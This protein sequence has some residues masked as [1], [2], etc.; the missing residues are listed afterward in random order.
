MGNLKQLSDATF[1]QDVLE[2]DGLVLVDFWAPWCGPC[3]AVAPV[4]EQIAREYEGRVTVA[5]LNVDENPETPSRYGVR[6]IPTIALFRGGEVIDG[7]LGAAPATFFTGMLDKH[8]DTVPAAE[9]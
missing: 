3:R 8:L 7:V 6:P 1:S 9:A 2:A 5:K 4:L